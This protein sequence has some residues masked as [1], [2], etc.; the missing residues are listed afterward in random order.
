M[1]NEFK[2]LNCVTQRVPQSMIIFNNDLEMVID[3]VDNTIIK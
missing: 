2:K 1:D 3:S